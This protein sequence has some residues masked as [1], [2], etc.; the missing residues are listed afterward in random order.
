ML[1]RAKERLQ[2]P[3]RA[4]T[5]TGISAVGLVEGLA[6][7]DA[8]IQVKGR[9]TLLQ[10]PP[11]DLVGPVDAQLH[12][13]GACWGARYSAPSRS[14]MPSCSATRPTDAQTTIRDAVVVTA[15]TRI[16][17]LVAVPVANEP[18]GASLLRRSGPREPPVP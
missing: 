16:A 8:K 14:R 10:P 13:A 3:E 18:S 6:P 7:G 4:R 11:E 1:E 12:R 15:S 9:G 2:I 17:T 5:P